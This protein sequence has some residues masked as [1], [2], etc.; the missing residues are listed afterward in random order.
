MKKELEAYLKEEQSRLLLYCLGK[1][2]IVTTEW[3]RDN[4]VKRANIAY[5][6]MGSS[7]LS[8]LIYNYY[9]D[10][11]IRMRE[12]LYY[13]ELDN[14]KLY[15][16]EDKKTVVAKHPNG[17]VYKATC[18]EGDEF[19]A[20][21]GIAIALTKLIMGLSNRDFKDICDRAINVSK[22]SKKAHKEK[23]D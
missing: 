3:L 8:K 5:S 20:Q 6:K 4:A 16:N 12:M 15:I 19:N 9:L 11:E 17:D 2:E 23:K 14:I 22:V 21:A 7:E 10:H 13:S 1:P 18:T